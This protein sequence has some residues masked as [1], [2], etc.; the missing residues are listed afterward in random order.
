MHS[1]INICAELPKYTGSVPDTWTGN[2]HSQPDLNNIYCTGK[3]TIQCHGQKSARH[4]VPALWRTHSNI[5][6]S[7]YQIKCK[8]QCFMKV[9]RDLSFIM[10]GGKRVEWKVLGYKFATESME[11]FA[12]WSTDTKFYKWGSRKNDRSPLTGCR[13]NSNFLEFNLTHLLH[14]AHK[15]KTLRNSFIFDKVFKV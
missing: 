7:G 9:L 6:I 5:Q 3:W 8:D 14:T 12:L 2:W 10:R 4:A 1:S 13:K 11:I 15:W